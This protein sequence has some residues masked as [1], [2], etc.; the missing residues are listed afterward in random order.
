MVELINEDLILLD[1]ELKSK[2][3]II[4]IITSLLEKANRINNRE[5][6]IKDIYKREEEVPTSMGMK[7]AIPH[8]K[9]EGVKATSLVFIRLKEEVIWNDEDRVK[10][11]FGI[12][13]PKENEDNIHLKILSSLARKL[14]NREYIELLGKVKDKQECVELISFGEFNN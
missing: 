3:D 5:V 6:F 7:I 14:I 2:E 11:I 9:S 4:N 12:A 1:I 8:A 10:F 13:V